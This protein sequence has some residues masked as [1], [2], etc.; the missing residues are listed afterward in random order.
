MLECEY[1]KT[2]LA[3]AKGAAGSKMFR[4]F[5]A[6]DGR[7]SR[8]VIR[9]G[10]L[11]CAFFVSTI[12]YHFGWIKEPHVT[13]IGL[14]R[15]LENNGWK[16]IVKVREGCV[17][18]WQEE[19]FGRETHRHVGIYLGNGRAISNSAAKGCPATHDYRKRGRS[20][21]ASGIGNEIEGLWWNDNI[22]S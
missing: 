2:Y 19:K 21:K 15:D 8:D 4:H 20:R 18:V 11:G 22:K 16:K 6:H 17:I 12:L 10:K 3:M 7:R 5:Y 1:F 13:V 9:G 14:T